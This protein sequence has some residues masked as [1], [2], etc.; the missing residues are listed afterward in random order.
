MVAFGPV[1]SIF[2]FLTFFVMLFVFKASAPLFQTAWFIES[3]FTQT[4]V[5]FAIRTRETPFY[6][7]KSSKLLLLNIV[8]ILAFALVLPFT[9]IGTF[10]GFVAL[11]PGFL[12][13]LAVFIVAYLGLVEIMKIWFYRRYAM[14]GEPAK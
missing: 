14:T 4:L 12:L 10:F 2:D 9:F 11:P 5:I 8:A 6:R 7:S 13:M 3:L 1:S